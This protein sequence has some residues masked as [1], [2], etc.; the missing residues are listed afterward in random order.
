MN[1][2]ISRTNPVERHWSLSRKAIPQKANR[3]PTVIQATQRKSTQANQN[4][5]LN[6]LPKR[7]PIDRARLQTKLK[8]KPLPKKWLEVLKREPVPMK[9]LDLKPMEGSR[10]KIEDL[11][12]IETL[13]G[14]LLQM[15]NTPIAKLELP[16]LPELPD[17]SRI[18][19]I[20]QG[21]SYQPTGEYS[22]TNIGFIRD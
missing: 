18:G 16:P 9:P 3:Q 5:F 11:A 2:P 22:G 15:D 21:P 20:G 14:K 19:F 4:Q 1:Q 6:P 8:V 17:K 10:A 13:E 7:P 12:K